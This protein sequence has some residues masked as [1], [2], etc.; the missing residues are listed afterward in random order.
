MSSPPWLSAWP[1]PS[2]GWAGLR[3]AQDKPDIDDEDGDIDDA[4]DDDGDDEDGND[5]FHVEHVVKNHLH[6]GVAVF[7]VN[8]KLFGL[9][10]AVLDMSLQLH[11]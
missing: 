8:S 3:R 2:L 9:T 1:F 7:A 6:P 11:V 10:C 4:D 5:D